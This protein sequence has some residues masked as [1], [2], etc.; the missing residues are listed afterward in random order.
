MFLYCLNNPTNLCDQN[1][2]SAEALQI[3]TLSMWWLCAIDAILPIGDIVYAAG[4]MVLSIVC[5]AVAAN[6][7]SNSSPE[8]VP[9]VTFDV[10]PQLP[11]NKNDDDDDDDDLDDDYYDN[12][13]NFGGRRKIGKPKGKTP[14]NNQ[15]QN[16]QFRDATRNVPKDIQQQIHQEIT[17]TGAG[18]H[19]IIEIVKDYSSGVLGIYFI[20]ASWEK[21]WRL[22][23]ERQY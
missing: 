19:D 9:R 11:P 22:I 2:R 7:S 13:D 1:G 4:I 23:N 18:Y 20:I 8:E 5:V 17:K 6:I 15:A 3:W 10:S 16:Q 14:G 12:D 21:S